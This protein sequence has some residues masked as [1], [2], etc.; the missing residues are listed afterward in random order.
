MKKYRFITI[1]QVNNEMFE[2]KPVYRIYNNKHG[3]QLGIISYYKQWKCYI[4]SSRPE[5]VF[6]DSCLLDVA[7][8]MKNYAGK[9]VKG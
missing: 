2:G 6:N 7:G 4:F 1:K 8:F 3:D 5:C 9:E